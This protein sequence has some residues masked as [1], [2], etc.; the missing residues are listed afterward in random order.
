MALLDTQCHKGNWISHRLVKRLGMLSLISTEFVSP[1]LFEASGAIV[2]ASGVVNL[3]WKWHP[4]S[5]RIHSGQ[6][7]V[8][9][10][11]DH[12]DVLFGVE[13]IKSERLLQVNELALIPLVQHKKSKKGDDA[14][15]DQARERQQK[16]KAA[17][18]E[19][20]RQQKQKES[21]E[22]DNARQQ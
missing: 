8:L 4:Q 3:N 18:D 20:K 17:L 15:I 12:L 10:H 2:R 7:Y 6:F 16:E 19:R 22:G 21:K 11:S 13:Y 14:A 5:T 9:P 1:K